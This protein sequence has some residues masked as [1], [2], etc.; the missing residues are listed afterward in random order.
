MKY[1]ANLSANYDGVVVDIGSFEPHEFMN[2]TQLKADA[3][4]SFGNAAVTEMIGDEVTRITE[5]VTG[6][7]PY[8]VKLCDVPGMDS[9]FAGY[10]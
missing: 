9:V 3:I 2:L 1:H 6:E 4:K 8:T 10:V 7:R 5:F